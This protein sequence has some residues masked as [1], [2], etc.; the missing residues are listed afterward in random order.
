MTLGQRILQIR[1]EHN[2]SQESF[3]EKLGTTRQTVSRWE[4]D[5]TYPTLENIV[6]ISRIFS[7]TTDS[8]LRDGIS[9]FDTESDTFVCGVY[10][11]TDSELVETEQFALLCYQTADETIL[12]T[13]LYRGFDTQKKRIAVCEYSKTDK[14]T[15]YAYLTENGTVIANSDSLKAQLTEPYDPSR[16]KAMHSA[17]AHLTAKMHKA[18]SV[19]QFKLEGKIIS[20]HPEYGMESRKLLDKID[21]ARKTVVIDG[22][23]YPLTDTSFPTVDFSNPYVLT[24]EEEF[25]VSSLRRSFLHSEKL[26]HHIQ[27]MIN[28][29]GMYKIYN[30]NLL[31]HGCIP[32]D[33]SG[34]LDTVNVFGTDLKG[35]SYL[36]AADKAVRQFFISKSTSPESDFLWYLW[37]G[38]KSP[39][40][41]K[42]TY[43]TFESYFT[44]EP[45]LLKE[46][47]NHYY[48]HINSE[49][50]CDMILE[51][52]GLSSDSSHIIN[53]HVPVKTGKGESPVKANGKLY[54]IDGGFSKPYQKT[55]GIAGY[56][57]IN[58]SYGFSITSHHPFTT[59][60][61]V[62]ENDFDLHSSKKIVEYNVERKRVA[63][64]DNGVRIKHKIKILS[65]L[66][67]GYKKG[68][69]REWGR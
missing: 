41:G 28:R 22:K 18:I 8:M 12:G 48:S 35:K 36:D 40:F 55:T 47:K 37:C 42:D 31:F 58:N 69:I 57:L 65:E 3:A 13:T 34:K 7:I 38:N 33:S 53:G 4:L 63:D 19:I 64:T 32:L 1:T 27:F 6:R 54:V 52:F 45:E 26:R 67:D 50:V 44:A 29:G 60:N 15:A 30:G 66:L 24:A 21:I 56:T 59:I 20:E 68:Y 61:D 14:R 17:D 10:R 25:V 62:I 23:S 11:S 43:T 2:L 39:L 49:S 9:T 5:Q 51:E 16:K 46:E